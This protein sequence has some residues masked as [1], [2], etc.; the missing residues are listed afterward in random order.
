MADMKSL[1]VK[2]TLYTS[3]TQVTKSFY[4]NKETGAIE[5]KAAAQMFDGVAETISQDFKAFGGTLKAADENTAVGFGLWNGHGEATKIVT[6]A[7]LPGT[8]DAAARTKDHFD[9]LPGP[10]ILMLDNDPHP[11]GKP[12]TPYGLFAVMDSLFPPFADA[13]KWVRGSVSA[14]VR[15]QGEQPSPGKGFHCYLPVADAS[16]IPRFGAV[17]FKRLWLDGQGFIAIGA[18]GAL[19]TR[20][21]VD[22]A[23][24]SPERL[25]FI[26]KPSIEGDGLEY[27]PPLAQWRDGGYMDTRL[28]PDL[29]DTEEA[30][31]RRLVDAAKLA[32]KG[33][34]DQVR[35]A[36]IERKSSEIAKEQGIDK[37]V[38]RKQ[39]EAIGTGKTVDLP[40]G[41]VLH[42]ASEGRATVAEVLADPGRYDGKALADPVEGTGYG[43][44]TAAF[45][46][47]PDGK[48]CI[49]SQAHGMGIR[50]FPKSQ[51]DMDAEAEARR[52][53]NAQRQAENGQSGGDRTLPSQSQEPQA[54]SQKK[55]PETVTQATV[56]S[57][58][59]QV[60]TPTV[61]SGTTTV[62]P[63]SSPASDNKSKPVTR[64]NTRQ[65]APQPTRS[66]AQ[67]SSGGGEGAAVRLAGNNGARQ[68]ATAP[69]KGSTGNHPSAAT[70]RKGGSVKATG[71]LADYGADYYNNDPQN[72]ES[73][74]VTVIGKDSQ[75]RTV[76]G[77]DL[78]R[79]MDETE[80]NIGDPVDIVFHGSET[81]T[82]PVPVRDKSGKV[83][84]YDDK[85]VERNAWE[86]R[87]AQTRQHQK[88]RHS[89]GQDA[90]ND[91]GQDNNQRHSG[92]QDACNDG[93]QDN[94]HGGRKPAGKAGRAKGAA[95]GGGVERLGADFDAK[96]AAIGR[97]PGVADLRRRLAAVPQASH[98]RVITIWESEPSGDMTRSDKLRGVSLAAEAYKASVWEAAEKLASEGNPEEAEKLVEQLRGKAAGDDAGLIKSLTGIDF[99]EVA[100]KLVQRIRDILESIQ[101]YLYP[102][103]T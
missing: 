102:G 12:L 23:V 37:A 89:G 75:E 17:L 36:W 41:F 19:L 48:P 98:K 31:Y 77:I 70:P 95:T 84:R 62:P 18:S 97:D 42:F 52:Q 74:F 64:Q 85:V 61:D 39:V 99:E 63:P 32:A 53:R 20:T 43:V 80:M 8:P 30:E 56:A 72:G 3:V 26:G 66:T 101:N 65:A 7:K 96:R 45:Y 79:A 50:Y 2:F 93:G 15:K 22:G 73:Y 21:V 60:P 13:A 14:G 28:L 103:P 29:T 69:R 90:C 10:G 81:V 4:L 59:P 92:G 76:W 82:V 38:A 91:G 1:P 100:R 58:V 5:K 47:N 78:K 34:A 94:N 88:Q 83:V 71:T 67:S 49:H 54:A 33:D 24:F 25:D 9:Y 16:D 86:V 27:A 6:R 57:P 40:P 68:P 87:Q 44:T 46:A 35:S 11:R 51:A 55:P